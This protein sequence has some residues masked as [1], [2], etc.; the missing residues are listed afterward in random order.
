MDAE[1]IENPI[2]KKIKEKSVLKKSSLSKTTLFRLQTSIHTTLQSSSSAFNARLAEEVLR[3]IQVNSH[4]NHYLTTLD[5]EIL[6]IT[7]ELA[8]L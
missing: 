7:Q 2:R 8:Q 4:L 1:N 6:Q 3:S 5:Q